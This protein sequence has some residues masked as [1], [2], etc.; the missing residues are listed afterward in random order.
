MRSPQP[1]AAATP[2]S[3]ACSR[4]WR[5]RDRGRSTSLS[6]AFLIRH[7]ASAT[8]KVLP[9]TKSLR[10]LRALLHFVFGR[11]RAVLDTAAPSDGGRPK[12]AAE[13]RS[14]KPEAMQVLPD[15]VF[16]LVC[17]FLVT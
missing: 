4:P 3:S 1:E 6:S 16:A 5:A 10:K 11:N 8:Y 17:R 2:A 14:E 12:A 13:G 15:D 9:K 7:E